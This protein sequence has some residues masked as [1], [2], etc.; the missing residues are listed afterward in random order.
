MGYRL[1]SLWHNTVISGNHQHYDI[2]HIGA[3]GTHGGKSLMP[4][5]IEKSHFL[6]IP[7]DLR[8]PDVLGNAA[9]LAGGYMS[10][11]DFIQQACLA[12]VNMSEHCSN[13]RPPLE[14]ISG[15]PLKFLSYLLFQRAFMFHH[16]LGFELQSNQL[17]DVITYD[18]I[19]RGHY[20]LLHEFEDNIR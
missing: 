9:R 3:P 13:H 17:G 15:A 7:G 19:S 12:V 16:Q 20:T 2:G 11:P 14:A 8:C 6:L 1:N 10:R 4:G 18:L 5:S